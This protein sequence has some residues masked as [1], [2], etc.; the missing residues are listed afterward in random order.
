[1]AGCGWQDFGFDFVG[2]DHIRS[3]IASRRVRNGLEKIVEECLTFL[4]SRYSEYEGIASLVGT[5]YDRGTVAPRRIKLR[6]HRVIMSR[7]LHEHMDS[8]IRA[9]NGRIGASR[10][11]LQIVVRDLEFGEIY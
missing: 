3:M 4:T 6:K 8:E 9:A 7:L 1:M 10:F 11:L 2:T 5:A